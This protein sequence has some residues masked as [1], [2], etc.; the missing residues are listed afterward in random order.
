M[1]FSVLI[2]YVLAVLDCASAVVSEAPWSGDGRRLRRWESR[3]RRHGSSNEYH[4]RPYWCALDF[5]GS[6]LHA[7]GSLSSSGLSNKP[8][9]LCTERGA[10]ASMVGW[11][12]IRS[13]V[14][15]TVVGTGSKKS[16]F[17]SY[18]SVPLWLASLSLFLLILFPFLLVQ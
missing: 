11:L 9:C 14:M 3:R 5:S 1:L 12:Q 10:K 6:R 17:S 2:R 18:S 15:L 13:V 7:V 4:G 16:T 8:A